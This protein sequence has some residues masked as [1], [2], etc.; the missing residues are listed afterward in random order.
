MKLILGMIGTILFVVSFIAHVYVRKKFKPEEM[1]FKDVYW[2][3]EEEQP[4]FIK[5]KKYLNLTFEGM[6]VAA[7]LIF[8]A[9]FV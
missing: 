9:V 5:Y 3:F 2:E 7:L 1:E 6:A 4:D 8:I